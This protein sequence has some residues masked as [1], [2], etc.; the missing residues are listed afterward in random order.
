MSGP[1]LTGQRVQLAGA[2]VLVPVLNLRLSRAHWGT[3]EQLEGGATLEAVP[4]LLALIGD[5][6]RRVDPSITDEQ[7]ED[8]LDA[9]NL[10]AVVAAMRGSGAYR[11]WC[12]QQAAEAGNAPAPQP[13]ASAGTGAPSSP[14]SRPPP[15]GDSP[16]SAS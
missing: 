15:A 2:T 7:L 6:L 3:I 16:T 12:E 5:N 11:A 1:A 10:G 13:P 14:P 4:A 9:D 8:W